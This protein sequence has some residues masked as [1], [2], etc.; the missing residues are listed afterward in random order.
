MQLIT[1]PN[2]INKAIPD[3]LTDFIIKRF[4]QLTEETDAPPI[5]ILVKHGDMNIPTTPSWG[6]YWINLIRPIA[7]NFDLIKKSSQTTRRIR[8]PD[9]TQ[10]SGPKFA[11]SRPSQL[12][13]VATKLLALGKIS[14]S[15]WRR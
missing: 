5:I 1:H 10:K 15:A 14:G 12:P 6:M 4:N 13:R 11:P 8:R 7:S 2:H 3:E 9:A